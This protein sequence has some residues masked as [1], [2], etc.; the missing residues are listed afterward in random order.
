[1][2]PASVFSIRTSKTFF[3]KRRSTISNV[4]RLLCTP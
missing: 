1:M 3:H 2:S 4:S